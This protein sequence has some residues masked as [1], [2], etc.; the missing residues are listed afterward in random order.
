MTKNAE[1]S[2]FQRVSGWC[3]LIAAAERVKSQKVVLSE[4]A[5]LVQ[6]DLLGSEGVLIISMQFEWYREC[7]YFTPVSKCYFEAGI[8][9]IIPP[10]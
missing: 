3:E 2:K 6:K 4:Y 10:I 7:S 9:N 8:F 5:A 1:Q